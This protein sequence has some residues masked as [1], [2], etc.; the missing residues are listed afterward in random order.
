MPDYAAMYRESRERIT[1]LVR[2]VS[3][4]QRARVVPACPEWTVIDTVA[5]LAANAVD[6]VAGRLT[7]I[8]NDEQTAAQVEQ[9]RGRTIDEILAEWDVAAEPA[10]RIIA[11]AAPQMLVA[12]VNDV[13]THEAD[14]RGALRAGR[15]PDT[16]W[17]AALELA[18]PL[19]RERLSHLGELTILAGDQ[20]LT[21]G[22]G[23]M[24]STKPAT[25]V[26][27]DI[28]EFWRSMLGR[29]SRAQMAAWKWTGNPE[30]YLQAIPGFGPTE[31][32]LAE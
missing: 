26:E 13:L 15:P 3:D 9:R 22:S 10:E 29:R 18:W 25:M 24:D 2:A 1:A 8:P 6:T 21:T 27:V 5:H 14:I 32:D 7:T 17:T 16:A 28:Y 11:V 30:P 23:E 20:R 19:F 12:W 4:E 31:L